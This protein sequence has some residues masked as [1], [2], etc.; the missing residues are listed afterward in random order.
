MRAVDVDALVLACAGNE[1]ARH[2]AALDAVGVA[3]HVDGD[4]WYDD[5]GG[6]SIYHDAVVLRP[7]S[8]VATAT[9]TLAGSLGARMAS[10][11]VLD[12]WDALDLTSLGFE[13]DDPQPWMVRWPR[14]IEARLRAGFSVEQVTS[15]DGLERFE[16]TTVVGFGAQPPEP[17]SVYGPGLLVDPRLGYWLGCHDGVPVTTVTTIAAAGVVGVYDVTT[18]PE[19]RQRGFASAAVATALREAT[20]TAG[21]GLPAVL[22]TGAAAA[23]VYRTLGFEDLAALSTWWRAGGGAR[24]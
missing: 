21:R 13:R 10:A 15:V 12:A 24:A 3:H 17:G 18:L 2:A 14:P 23:S 8:D 20:L 7:S 9:A 11:S 6:P 16:A 5:G 19:Y 22:S 1:A 4:A